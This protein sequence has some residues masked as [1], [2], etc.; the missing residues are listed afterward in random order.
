VHLADVRY[1]LSNRLSRQRQETRK[2][3]QISLPLANRCWSRRWCLTSPPVLNEDRLKGRLSL[4]SR[5]LGWRAWD[6][7]RINGVMGGAGAP[8]RAAWLACSPDNSLLSVSLW[9]RL[10]EHP[11][12]SLLQ[13][14]F[15]VHRAIE[16][17]GATRWRHWLKGHPALRLLAS[18][19]LSAI[20]ASAFVPIH[21]H[22]LYET[23]REPGVAASSGPQLPR[24][25]R[26]GQ[27]ITS[28]RRDI[29]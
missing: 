27:Q 6:A 25:R 14:L 4:P 3:R 28:G 7:A 12:I 19:C 1:R 17:D 16:E 9:L 24:A 15:A 13:N 10:H 23:H 22:L 2:K 8:K 26:V 20:R 11:L 18:E 5:L 21:V 29:R